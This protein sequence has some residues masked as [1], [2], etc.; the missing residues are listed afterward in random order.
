MMNIVVSGA[1]GSG[2]STLAAEL[3]RSLGAAL[4][5]LD[6]ITNPVLEAVTAS[7]P[8]GAHWNAPELRPVIRPAR[9]AALRAVLADQVRAGVDSVLVAPFTAELQGGAEW[10]ELVEAAGAEPTVVWLRASPELLAERRRLRSADRDAHIVDSPADAAPRVPHLVVDAALTTGQQLASVLRRLGGG[11]ALPASSAVFSRTF[12]AALFDL[13]GTLI[14]STPAVNRSWE[15]LGREFG[16]TLD[17]MAAGHGQPA[18]QVIAALFPPELAE[19]ALVRVTEIEADEL[20]D[21]IALDGAAALLD[22]LP[23]PQRAIVTSGTRLIAGNRVAAA[24]LTSPAVFVT[25]DDVTRGKPHPEPYLLAASRLGVDPADCVVFE[26]APAGLAAARAA[27]CA[28]VAIAGTHDAAEL[29]ADLIVD[30][31]FQL[32]AL[33]A[34][35]GG[36]RLAPA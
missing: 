14:D 24:G 20:D 32:R 29:D 1:A 25:F 33:P 16:L 2:K 26:D 23:D 36:F 15:Q 5:D 21:V 9:Y 27:G 10:R 6:T 22:S 35:G 4:L 28:T 8:S 19:A 18:A 17:L 11:R 30:G 12:S 31:L 34:E 3:A 7:L 13:D